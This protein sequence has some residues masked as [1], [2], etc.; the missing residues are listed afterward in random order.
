MDYRAY[1]AMIGPMML[2]MLLPP[3]MYF[4]PFI[5]VWAAMSFPRILGWRTPLELWRMTVK[6]GGG[7]IAWLNL[8]AAHQM[9]AE[10]KEARE[11]Y[12]QCL[13]HYP[14]TGVALLNL[15]L[16]EGMEGRPESAKAKLEDC[17]RLN[18]RYRVGW[19]MLRQVYEHLK[20]KQNAER[21]QKHVEALG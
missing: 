1:S 14:D 7:P 9:R 3:A 2:L 15:G 12:A 6:D 8:G 21:C 17:V 11:C 19:V 10:F 18:P 5:A 20:D 13:K 4:N 16:I